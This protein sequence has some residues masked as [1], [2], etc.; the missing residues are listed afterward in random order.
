ML[1]KQWFDE[2]SYFQDGVGG[3]LLN[4]K[5]NFIDSNGR[6]LSNQWFDELY[7]FE[8]GFAKVKL[9]GKDGKID[10]CGKLYI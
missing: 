4:N 9:N 6:L 2:A 5:W 10:R 7:Y 3:V 1:S 8:D